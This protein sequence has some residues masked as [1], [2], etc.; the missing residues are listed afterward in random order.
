MSIKNILP[1]WHP[2]TNSP[3]N[4][5]RIFRAFLSGIM[6][7]AGVTRLAKSHSRI[8]FSRF[9]P[10]VKF[11]FGFCGRPER[12]PSPL[13]SSGG[14]VFPVVSAALPPSLPRAASNHL[15]AREQSKRSRS[16]LI[17]TLFQIFGNFSWLFYP[18]EYVL[19]TIF[20][21]W[22]FFRVKFSSRRKTFW[23]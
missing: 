13:L 5:N 20:V 17:V 21:K 3:G 18:T 12:S 15:L 22:M 19:F 23:I 1:W 10:G 8:S 6:S 2:I 11:T 4:R 16:R 7:P 9:S 14:D